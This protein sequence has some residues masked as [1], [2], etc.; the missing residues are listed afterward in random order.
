MLFSFLKRHNLFYFCWALSVLSALQSDVVIAQH[1]RTASEKLVCLSLQD[2]GTCACWQVVKI[3]KEHKLS[4]PLKD[5]EAAM[6][7]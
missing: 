5:L 6:L 1:L 4:A 3:D 7:R 2:Q